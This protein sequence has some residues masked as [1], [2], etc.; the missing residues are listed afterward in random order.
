MKRWAVIILKTNGFLDCFSVYAE[1]KRQAK[2]K[3]VATMFDHF[4][5]CKFVNIFDY[6][7]FYGL[8]SP[9]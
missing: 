9:Y 3:A 8:T 4:P 6:Y 2:V 1:S 7:E 5:E